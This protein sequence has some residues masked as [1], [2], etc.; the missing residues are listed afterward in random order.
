MKW[1]YPYTI[2]LVTTDIS[3][4][5]AGYPRQTNIF[6]I[7]TKLHCI[8]AHFPLVLM[9]LKIEYMYLKISS[10]INQFSYK[11]EGGNSRSSIKM[12]YGW[13]GE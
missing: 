8:S 7:T 6:Y 11:L 4:K 2:R 9:I 1:A 5:L 10:S 13:E 3:L 12:C